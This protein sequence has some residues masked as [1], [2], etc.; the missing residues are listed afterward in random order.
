MAD[1]ARIPSDESERLAA[2]RST[3]ILDT[4]AES[5]FD[6]LVELAVTICDT[7]IALVS[8]VDEHRQWFKARVGLDATETPREV[9]FCA[10]AILDVE[11][12]VVP[13]ARVDPRFADNPLV[14]GAP[15]VVFYAGM[16]LTAGGGSALGTLCVIDRVPR[17]LT[18]AQLRAL[19]VLGRAA[20]AQL[21]A[22]RNAAAY[23]QLAEELDGF[24]SRSLDMLCVADTNGYFTRLNPAWSESLGWQL[25]ELMSRP[26]VDFVHPEDRGK[27]IEEARR[28]SEGN[29]TV[30][31]ENRYRTKDGSYRWLSWSA[32]LAPD[33][34]R[35]FA[36]ARD[37]TDERQ[38][39]AALQHSEARLAALFE[40][41]VDGILT[42]D[43][44]GVI[45]SVNGAAQQLFGYGA[46]ELIGE[47]VSMLM[48][49]PYRSAHDGYLERYR[50][51][52]Q[53]S[54][55]GRGRDLTG[56]RKDGTT[57]PMYLAVGEL[58]GMARREFAG[59]VRDLSARDAVL[60]R[61]ETQSRALARASTE[62]QSANRLKS[63]FLANMSHELRT[64]LNGILGFARLLHDAEAGPVNDRQ[65][66][67]LGLVLTSADHLLQLIN[68]VLDLS[69]VEAGALEFQPRTIDLEEIIAETRG[70]VREIAAKKRLAID[71]D[72]AA[73]LRELFVDPARLKQV[74][75]NYLSNAIKF[76]PQDGRIIIRA[77]PDT[78]DQFRLEVVDGGVGIAPEDQH[79][80]F[81]EFQ[82]LD[83]G[84]D[85]KHEG[86]GLGLALTK[87]LVEAQGG[88]VGVSSRLGVGS[89]FYAV[90]PRSVAAAST[91]G[92]S[93]PQASSPERVVPTSGGSPGSSAGRGRVLVLD[94]DAKDRAWLTRVLEDAGYTVDAVATG[95]DAIAMSANRHYDAVTLDMFLPD[96]T[97]L[98]VLA[99]LRRSGLNRAAPA[100]LVTVVA[101]SNIAS[102]VE[103]CDFITKPAQ[104][105]QLLGALERAGVASPVH[106]V[107]IVDDDPA[108]VEVAESVLRR[109]GVDV[110]V[111]RDGQQALALARDTTFS[112]VILDLVM[113]VVDGFEFLLEF[114]RLPGAAL[115]PV[116]VWSSKD[117]T[118][119]DRARLS[120]SAQAVVRKGSGASEALVA[121]LLEQLGG[122]R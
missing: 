10:H 82:Q 86:T 7:P 73:E 37:I 1:S 89:T 112:A 67:F 105:H 39:G 107:L 116:V 11:P 108:A 4:P 17:E 15:N 34:Q 94:D 59:I 119:G 120:T 35:L 24:F 19:R 25:D 121:A 51:T 63:E 43:E 2:L 75:Y 23:R 62:A 33:G 6:E 87:Q 5:G 102:G 64:P 65:R 79:R 13:D 69:K 44:Y 96:M 57:F 38:M 29:E 8:L 30:A 70:V 40:A 106:P 97:G 26:F 22:R 95:A 54:I 31:F 100:I 48:P 72:V 42:I 84:A 99:A 98:D 103:I 3:H 115:T 12:F 58:A 9:A 104:P 122:S 18:E 16:P 50:R 14:T 77:R 101:D 56:R 47:N 91:D 109:Q 41:A 71:V 81:A 76:S 113:P 55:I 36:A 90:L 53:S 80:L 45:L 21:E 92:E 66:E 117:L 46:D 93:A 88:H 60:Q 114:R 83:A 110:A 20:S 111:A 52:G 85:K 28:L 61:L 32:S 49:E 27:T 74:L 118:A 78:D 68:D